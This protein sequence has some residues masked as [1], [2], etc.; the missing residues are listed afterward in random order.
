LEHARFE[1]YETWDMCMLGI[2]SPA[3]LCTF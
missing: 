2:T 1:Q 3:A